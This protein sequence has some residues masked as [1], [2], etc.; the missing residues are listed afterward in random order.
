MFHKVENIAIKYWISVV[1]RPQNPFNKRKLTGRYKTKFTEWKNKSKAKKTCFLSPTQDDQ[2]QSNYWIAINRGPEWV[3]CGSWRSH[4]YWQLIF[5]LNRI[6]AHNNYPLSPLLCWDKR[7]NGLSRIET[8][9]SSAL[10]RSSRKPRPL[11]R[12]HLPNILTSSESHHSPRRTN[13]EEN[14]TWLTATI[15]HKL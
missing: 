12:L 1:Q 5:Y 13:E 6:A 8:S 11:V 7:N 10:L 4:C 2:Q 15:C 14:C 3:P 9:G